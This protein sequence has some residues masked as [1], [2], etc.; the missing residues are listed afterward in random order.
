MAAAGLVDNRSR[1]RAAI[2]AGTIEVAVAIALVNGLAASG[3]LP[4]ASS[5]TSIFSVDPSPSPTPPPPPPHEQSKAS[6]KAA[7]P[8]SRSHAAAVLTVPSPLPSLPIP[9]ATRPALGMAPT[10]GAADRPGP[11]SGA[12]G[13]GNGTGSGGFGSGEGDGDDGAELIGGRITDGDYPDA[14]REA[15]AQGTTQTEIAVDARG[16]GTGCRVTRSSGNALLDA[17]TCR[18]ALKRFR[19]RPA[20]DAAGNAVPGSIFFDQKWEIGRIDDDPGQ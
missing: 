16:R 2:L 1:V 9:A 8:N 11:G 17:T 15:R 4:A 3:T 19:F 7:P 10:N 12:G 14:A 20:R 13:A 18:L 5:L 6:G